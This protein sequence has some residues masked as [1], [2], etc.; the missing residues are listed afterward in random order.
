MNRRSA[1][2][3]ALF[4]VVGFALTSTAQAAPPQDPLGVVTIKAG[5]PIHVAYW[6]VVAGAD[7]SL[8]TDTKR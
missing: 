5:Q 7:S 6:M 2:L 3:I 4:L 1:F 8:G